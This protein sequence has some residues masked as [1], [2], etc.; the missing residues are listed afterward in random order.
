MHIYMHAYRYHTCSHTH[1][2]TQ[3]NL[4]AAQRVSPSWH[5]CL[6]GETQAESMNPYSN[7]KE[8]RELNGLTWDKYIYQILLDHATVRKVHFL[9][10]WI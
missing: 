6:V 4:T 10:A 3:W 8:L 9:N 2:N 1:A 7:S 5:Y